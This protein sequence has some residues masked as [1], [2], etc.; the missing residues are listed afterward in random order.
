MPALPSRTR[1]TLFGLLAIVLWS[2]VVGLIRSV[3]EGLGP[4]GGAAMIYS[5]SAVF[6]LVALGVPKWRSFPRPYLIV[7]SLLFVS[8]EICLSLSLG[9]ANTRLQAIEVGMINYLWPCFTVLMALAINGQKAKWWLLPG[10]LLSLFGIGWIMSGEGGWSPAQM[11]ANVRSNPLSY[12]L[13]FSGAVIWALYCNLTKKIAQGS[14]GVVLFIVLTALALWL[15]YAFSAE[16]GMQFSAGVT[17]TLLC[18]GVAMGAGYAAWNVGILRG[19]MTLLAT[20]SYFT[21]V[22]SAVFA[23]LVLHTSLTASF[24]QG[25]AMVTLGSLICWRATRGNYRKLSAVVAMLN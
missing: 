25:V 19:N 24:W 22:L 18:A 11:L 16:S 5:V 14:N 21:P 4:I 12:A 7:G 9:Y 3:S 10:L 2:S 6:L 1:A 23:A 13:A 8:Y 15:K 17:V 20:V